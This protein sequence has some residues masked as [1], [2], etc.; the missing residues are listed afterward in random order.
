MTF[1]PSKL[2]PRRR[3]Q[4]VLVGATL[5]LLLLVAVAWLTL[6]RLMEPM[7]RRKLQ[8]MV[9]SRLDA[10]LDL[11]SLSYLPPYGVRVRDAALV[12]PDAATGDVQVLKIGRLD[13]RLA[14]PPWK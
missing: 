4:R 5:G 1:S 10:R 9:S 11:G 8:A 3:W 2:L 14:K 6:P 12:A 7:I 13:L